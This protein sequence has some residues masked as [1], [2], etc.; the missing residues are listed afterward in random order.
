[1]Y[2]IVFTIFMVL[3]AFCNMISERRITSVEQAIEIYCMVK[4]SDPL[5]W[6]MADHIYDHV[7]KAVETSPTGP[8]SIYDCWYT[9][10]NR[11]AL[12]ILA[13]LF[14]LLGLFTVI[15]SMRI[16]LERRLKMKFN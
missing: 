5:N 2:W 1:M 15:H 4:H 7:V 3:A 6:D 8:P 11:P 14:G 9:G 10:F 13:C 16:S 12:K